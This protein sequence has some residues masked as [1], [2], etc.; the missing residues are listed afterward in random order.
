MYHQ[1]YNTLHDTWM[2]PS[3]GNTYQV[4]KIILVLYNLGQG[5]DIIVI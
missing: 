2:P 3:Q 1:Q 4:L 5:N